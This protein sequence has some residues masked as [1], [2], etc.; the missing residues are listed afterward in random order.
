MATDALI[1]DL[2]IRGADDWV[3]AAEVA[4]VA[5]S[6][7]GARTNDDIKTLSLELIHEVLSAGLMEAGDV[8]EGGSFPWEASPDE[9]AARIDHSWEQLDHDPNLGEV[10]WL[11]NTYAGNKRAQSGPK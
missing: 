4:W 1:N 8:T 9:A 11:A 2:L 10:C 7:G 6:V 3:T 5:K